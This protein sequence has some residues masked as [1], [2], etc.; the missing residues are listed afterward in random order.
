MGFIVFEGPDGSGKS[1][2]LDNVANK[3]RE[4][5]DKTIKLT[6]EPGGTP[7][8]QEI[9]KVLFNED[10]EMS[11]RASTLLFIADRAEHFEKKLKKYARDPNVILLSDRYWETTLVYQRILHDWSFE[12]MRM[13]HNLATG[14]LQPDY[15]FI[16]TSDKPHGYTDENKYDKK[17]ETFREKANILYKSLEEHP[18][19]SYSLINVDTTYKNWDEYEDMIIKTI[20]EKSL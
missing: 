12:E 18:M 4:K 19:I 7:A 13:M 2:L 5:T 16:V 6:K 11:E 8:G 14:G 9:R 17:S 1:T 10:F 15:T 20:M 3:L